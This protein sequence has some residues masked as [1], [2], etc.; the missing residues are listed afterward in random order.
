MV[1]WFVGTSVLAV[2][3]VFR[4]PTFDY[5]LLIV[6]SVLPTIDRVA[7]PEAPLSSVVVA[8]AVLVVVMV[9][10][11][12]RKPIRRTLLGL[13]IGLFLH[14]VA[15]GAWQDPSTFWWPLAGT[16]PAD[17]VHPTFGRGWW[18]LP[19]EVAGLVMCVVVWRRGDLGS[20][21]RRTEFVRSGRLH[22]PVS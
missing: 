22:L 7:V 21:Q 6:G 2:W 13:P 20:P 17:G 16:G 4:D 5:R 1:L 18:I 8:V 15:A 19:L 11:A 10:T 3:W 14:L 9:A 12:G